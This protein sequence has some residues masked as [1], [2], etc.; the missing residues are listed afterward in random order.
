MPKTFLT[1]GVIVEWLEP[2]VVAAA[3]RVYI[4]QWAKCFSQCPVA[5]YSN[6]LINSFMA[7]L[8]ARYEHIWYQNNGYNIPY[9]MAEMTFMNMHI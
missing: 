6:K 2:F 7:L 1:I 4:P 5:V 8:F 3:I 9:P